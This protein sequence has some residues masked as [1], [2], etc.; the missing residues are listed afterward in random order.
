MQLLLTKH[1][2][3]RVAVAIIIVFTAT[4]LPWWVSLLIAIVC[5]FYFNSYY[6]II[7]F[8]FFMDTI[9]GSSFFLTI[10]TILIFILSFPIKNRISFYDQ[11]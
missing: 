11:E 7:A 1:I 2:I 5:T 8:G 4:T 10:V 9:F 6:E 3:Y